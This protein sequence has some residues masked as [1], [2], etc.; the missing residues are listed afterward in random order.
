MRRTISILTA[1]LCLS[2]IGTVSFGVTSAITE[3]RLAMI[4]EL[5]DIVDQAPEPPNVSPDDLL[6]RGRDNYQSAHYAEAVNDLRAAAEAFLTPDQMKT[7]VNTGKFESLPK[8]QTAVIYLAMAYAKLGREAEAREQIHR[9][10][11]SESITPTYAGLPL[12]PDVADFEQVAQRISPAMQL[13]ANTALAALHNVPMQPA[14]QVAQ[15]PPAPAPPPAAPPPAAAQPVTAPA[16][17]PTA[18]AQAQPV[19]AVV[20]PSIPEQQRTIEERVAA[21]RVAAQREAEQRVAAARAAAEQEAQQRIANERATIER[22]AQERIA[23]ERA[24]IQQAADETIAVERATAQQQIA[25][26]RAAAER[27]AQQR[28]AAAEAE[29]RRAVLAA[30]RQADAMANTGR[31]DEAKAMYL[32]LL[33]VPNADRESVAVAAT[34]L[35]RTGDYPDAVRAFEK[36][37]AFAR[38]EEDLRYYNAVSLYETGRYDQAKKELAC[39]LPFIQITD[40]VSRYRAKIEQTQPMPRSVVR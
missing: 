10:V 34:G 16:Q 36:L 35:Y 25:Q 19:P 2:L 31:L 11:V 12:G 26:A 8:F 21:E 37:G 32:Q 23:A 15:A 24:A 29:S 3:E 6:Q 22:Q 38:G 17:Q 1:F 39:A 40:D 28:I 5:H 9:L 13:P 7:Y 27:E 20:Q 18:V 30:L 33:N 4:A 14:T